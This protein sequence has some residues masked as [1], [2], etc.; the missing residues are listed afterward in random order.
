MSRLVWGRSLKSKVNK[1]IPLWRCVDGLLSLT[2]CSC[3]PYTEIIMNQSFLF[4]L[5]FSFF[6]KN[7]KRIDYSGSRLVKGSKLRIVSILYAVKSSLQSPNLMLEPM[8]STSFLNFQKVKSW[9][10][11]SISNGKIDNSLQTH[12]DTT[13]CWLTALGYVHFV[14]ILTRTRKPERK[15]SICIKRISSWKLIDK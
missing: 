10:L 8:H 3:S 15:R 9:R 12:I 7:R 4:F 6:R 2:N 14:W 13:S 1:I 11:V 5:F